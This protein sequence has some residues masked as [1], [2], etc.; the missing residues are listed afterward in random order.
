MRPNGM[1]AGILILL[2]L[3]NACFA[4]QRGTAQSVGMD[5]AGLEQARDYALTGG[6]SGCIIR[7]GK[8]VMSWGDEKKRYDLKS[9][10]K[11]IGQIRPQNS[12]NLLRLLPRATGKPAGSTR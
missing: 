12:I 3:S 7:H 5:K 4:W 8:L 9:T 1:Q 2:V 10:T 6:G 11:S